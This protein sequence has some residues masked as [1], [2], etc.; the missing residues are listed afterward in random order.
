MLPYIELKWAAHSVVWNCHGLGVRFI[1]FFSVASIY[2]NIWRELPVCVTSMFFTQ[3]NMHRL[4]SLFLLLSL[5]PFLSLVLTLSHVTTLH[6][7]I[8]PTLVSEVK[9]AQLCPILC[10]LM[11]YTARG[12]LQGRILEWVALPFSRGSSQPRDQ[13]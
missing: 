1:N 5:L 4:W 7:M 6:H 8:L 9:V 10:D 13:T 2:F 3:V 12:I 11:D